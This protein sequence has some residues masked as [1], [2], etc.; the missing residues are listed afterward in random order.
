MAFANFR[1]ILRLS[2]FEK[3]KSR[4]YEHVRRDLDPNEVWEI[5]GEL[6][7]GAFGKVYKAKNKET[8]ALAAAKVIE[9]N[10][11]EE[12]EDYIVE[13]EILATCDH[14]YIVKLLGAYYYDG[15]LW[16]MIEF[17]PGGAVDAI[18]LELDR[19]LTEPQIQVVCRQ[20]LEALTFL[21]GKKIIHRDL[22]AGNVLM[23]LEGDIRLADFGVSAKNLKTLQKRDSFI[24]TPY[25][26][27]PEV[28]M[29]E[30]MKDTPYDYKAD[31]WSLGITLIEMAQIE[32][33]HH[34]LNPMRVLLKIAKSDPPTLLS[35]SK[36]SAEFRDFLK[37]ALDKNPETRP[38]AAQLLEHPF[39]SSVTSNKALR[40]LVAEAKAEVMEEIEDGRDEGDEEDAVEAASPLENHTRDSSEV[41]QLSIDADKLLKESPFTP[42]PPS[43]PQDGANGPSEPPGH[44]ALPATSPLDV[45]PGNENGQ[46]VPVPLRKF[47]PVSM[48]AR[49]QVS[50]EKQAADQGGDLSPAASRSQKASQSRPNSSALETLRSELTNGSLEL[51]TPGAQSLSK[52]DSDCG[53]VSTSGS[54]DF[55]T[56]LSA[57]M[58]VNKESGSLSIKD[59]RLHN[60]TLKR[61]RKFVVDGV[62]VSITTSKIISEDEKKD[63][64]MRF[65]RRQELRELRLLQK[66]EHRNQTQLSSKHELQLEQ[67]HKRFEQEINAKKK[68]FDIE[69]ENLERQQ[70]QQVEKMEQDHAVRRREEAKRIRLEQE[71]DYAKFQEQLKLMKKEVKNE[72]EKLPRQQRKESM[73]QKMEE[74]TQKKQLLDRDF[75]AKQKEDLELAMKRITADNRREICDKERECLT[76]K[77]EL[78]RDREA[79]LWEM[80]EHHLQ[81]RHQ[82]VKQQLKDQYFLQRHELLRKHEKE[83][84][85]MQRYNQR[86][87]EQLKVRQQQEKARLPKIQ[88]SEG[89]TRMAM[90][91]KSLH[92]NGAGSAAEQREKIKQ[93]SQQEEKRQKAERLQQQQK[94]ENQM[95]DMLAQCDSNMSELQQLQNE[96]CHL[97]IEHE[98]QKLKALDE[99]HNQN[100]KEWRDKLRPRK[101]A[102]EEDLNQKKREQEMFF[103]MNEESE[104]ANPTSPNKVTKFFPYSSADAAS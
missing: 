43:Q 21:H 28:V 47:R 9:T 17:C 46:A 53:S 63:E 8:G 104:C 41:S 16:I 93:F 24:G 14:P 35:P 72:V 23:T 58:S 90:Y 78:L 99:S 101:K 13:I 94:H 6:G 18:M 37:T 20:M 75:V 102:L 54:T 56:S 10:S 36:W 64:E 88:R 50:E 3:R 44:G 39:V 62:E 1:R 66:E 68:F 29:C 26:M 83:R 59:S 85:Q 79:A 57:D 40:E 91:K 82:L 52:R 103:K 73:K 69:L 60:K 25:W 70:K 74:H 51:P 89:K 61:T 95:R 4:E 76:R 27:A 87:I 22:K 32:P 80:E 45:A 34:E 5:V 98:T 19:G 97:L 2:T 31:I 30:T 84:E 96:K 71:R 12:L 7:D 38:S 100:L 65:L 42:P 81:E 67:M 77:Q 33:P 49:I 11:E 15:K 55:G 92:I 48:G 86:M